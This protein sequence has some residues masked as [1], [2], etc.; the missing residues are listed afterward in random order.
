LA[1]GFINYQISFIHY[2]SGFSVT[3]SKPSG[4]LGQ[5]QI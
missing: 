5:F 1:F 3:P 2:F 4:K